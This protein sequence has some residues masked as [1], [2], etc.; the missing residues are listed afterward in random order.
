MFNQ[1]KRQE[2]PAPLFIVG[3]WRSGT[4]YLH[5]VLSLSPGFAHISPLASGLPW[6]V[7]GI[8]RAFQPLLKKALPADRYIDNVEV[9]IDSPQED[10]IAL[11]NMIPLSY[12]HGIYFP[13]RFDYH[14]RRGV[15]MDNTTTKEIALW[16]KYLLHFLG[17]V[18]RSQGDK[19]VLMKNPVYS[20][21][22]PRL[23]KLW[24]DAKFIHI[25]RNPYVVY[26]STKYFYTRLLQELAL[27]D[28]ENVDIP[29][30]VLRTYP[31]IM[32][33]L[34]RDGTSLP[35]NQ[36]MEIRFEALEQEP[37][38]TL[39]KIHNRLEISGFGQTKSRFKRYLEKKA[40]YKK[41][42]YEYETNDMTRVSQQWSEFIQRWGYDVP[43]N[44]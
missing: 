39:E 20:A 18:S 32:N 44:R 19:P 13:K 41:N 15:F 26:P 42:V 37:L 24:P 33:A 28:Y 6:D 10:S 5:N 11:A 40:S 27:Q 25:H 16:E 23:L 8:V 21:H 4:T 1:R 7:L 22:I 36:F 14:F 30:L 43:E 9:N 31:K 34:I 2:L 17:K 35:D 12:Y 38:N 3:H 29:T